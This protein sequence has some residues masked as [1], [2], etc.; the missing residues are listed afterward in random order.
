MFG[1]DR[2]TN[3]YISFS[4]I[5]NGK[6]SRYKTLIAACADDK[7]LAESDYDNI[8]MST[9]Q[10]WDIV[11][12]I[13]KVKQLIIETTWQEKLEEERGVV[14]RLKQNWERFREGNHAPPFST[15][16]SQTAQN[17]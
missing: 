10:T 5:V 11:K 17:E 9:S 4:T 7:I 2:H 16:I 1:Q 12:T 3:I 8:N 14:H 15:C 6:S 13:A